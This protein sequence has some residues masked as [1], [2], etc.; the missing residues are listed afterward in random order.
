MTFADGQQARVGD[1]AFTDPDTQGMFQSEFRYA[2]SWREGPR[3]FR[4]DPIHLDLREAPFGARQLYAPLGV[5][6]DALPDD[7]GRRLLVRAHNLPRGQQ[8]EPD[9]LRI[10]GSNGLGAL[11]FSDGDSPPATRQHALPNIALADLIDAALDIEAGRTPTAEHLRA[12]LVT[13]SSPGGS[14]PK[15]VLDDKLGNWIAKFPSPE[16]D[17]RFDV[18]GLEATCMRLARNAGIT[19]P[20]TRL[21]K[22]GRRKVLLVRRYDVAPHGGR[23][24]VVSL[25]TLCGER[26][27]VYVQSYGEVANTLRRA[28]GRIDDI[29]DLFRIMVFNAAIG[30]T[31][32]HLKNL[33]MIH[34]PHG[35]VLAPAIDL[36]PDVGERR[37]HC[38]SFLYSHACPTR[39]ELRTVAKHWNVASADA[40]IDQTINAVAAFR[41]TARTLRVTAACANEIAR[42]IQTRCDRLRG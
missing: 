25:K 15:A 8:G 1:L 21:V 28:T 35:Y 27:G 14:R 7:W 13:G 22:A 4:I 6:E 9:L 30:N 31:D 38:L 20:D 41:S 40:L 11:A 37:E 33:W 29:N 34:G 10:L 3:S 24:H 16:R 23:H 32:D 12:L 26:T 5:F 39:A 18:V 17:G 2:P 36:V 19:V 42:D